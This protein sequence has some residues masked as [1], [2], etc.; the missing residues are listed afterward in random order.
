MQLARPAGPLALGDLDA[1]AQPGLGERLHRRDRHRGARRE[2]GQEVLV[3][4]RERVPRRWSKAAITPIARSRT[5]SG[6]SS[7][8]V[9]RSR[10]RPGRPRAGRS[11]DEIRSGL[12]SPIT[13]RQ[14]APSVGSRIDLAASARL[15]GGR[16]DDQVAGAPPGAAARCAPGSVAGPG[17]P[18]PSRSARASR[19]RACAPSAAVASSSR[20]DAR[21]RALRA[22]P[23]PL[24]DPCRGLSPRCDSFPTDDRT[25][26]PGVGRVEGDTVRA[27]EAPGMLAWL[28]GEGGHETGEEHQLEAVELLAP[29]PRAA[30]RP[31]LLRVRGARGHRLAP[32][33]RRDPAGLVRGA[34]VLLLEPG[35]RPRPRASRS[36]GPRR[37]ASS[38]SSSRS[39]R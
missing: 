22:G 12:C 14:A 23:A 6:T 36:A 28:R 4:R 20:S 1:L 11:T 19:R 9:G 3:A 13:R 15:A 38:T 33:G 26:T 29:V 24:L 25:G 39:P 37:R 21:P 35:V 10:S 27:L 2:A 8:V 16:R 32:A 18:W 5:I 34:D 30:Q 31:R 7:A 17:R